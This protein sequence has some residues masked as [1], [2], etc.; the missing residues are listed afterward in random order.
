MKYLEDQI[1]RIHGFIHFRYIFRAN[2]S[3]RCRLCLK[4]KSGKEF[5][6]KP[7]INKES[8]IKLIIKKIKKELVKEEKN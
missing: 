2:Y 7:L 4:E 5:I 6:K 3:L 8:I 1:C